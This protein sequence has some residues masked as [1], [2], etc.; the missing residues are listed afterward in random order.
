MK[1]PT[2]IEELREEFLDLMRGG[3]APDVYDWEKIADWWLS[4]IAEREQEIA[5][6][7]ESIKILPDSK[8]K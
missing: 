1:P 4:K 2:A 7:I 6:G 3:G 5:E 8:K